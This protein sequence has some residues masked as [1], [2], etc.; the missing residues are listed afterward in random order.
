MLKIDLHT[1]ILPERWP[2]W[3]RKSGYAGWIELAH[4]RP[5][6]ARMLKTTSID[7][8]TPPQSFREIGCNCWDP[9]VRLGEM[10]RAGVTSQVISTVPVMFS[11][12]AKPGDASALAEL[13][14]D[15]I[16]SVAR[17]APMME[18]VRRFIGLGTVPM[19][20]PDAACRELE[21]CVRVL[22]MPGIQIGTNVNGAYLDDGGV[23]QVLGEAA[24]LGACVLVHPWEMYGQER[25]SKFWMPWLVGMPAETA[26]AIVT[27]M[28]GGVF[29]R[30]PALRL[31]FA[32][33][34]GSFPGT[35]GRVSH[36]RACR[37][38]LFPAGSLDPRSYLRPAR[39]AAAFYVDSLVHDRHAMRLLLELFGET[40][41]ALGSDYP[42][43]LG[44]ERA[45]ELLEAMAEELRGWRG[46]GVIARMLAGTALE[47]LGLRPA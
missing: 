47:F 14:N 45:G 4:E 2:S 21:R 40:R 13:L 6:C 7:G 27:A 11:Y 36:G 37:P 5:G 33:G 3:T 8:S 26:A 24:R 28:F 1:H 39:P 43:P 15:H 18:G 9:G 34:G 17:D 42:F 38:D 23:Q 32:H 30:F 44:E 35:V 22:G 25:I 12:W 20:D 16:A 41:I 29:E 19:Q 31:C 46:E 10:D